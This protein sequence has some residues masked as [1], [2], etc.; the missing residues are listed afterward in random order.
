MQRLA[1]WIELDLTDAASNGPGWY[2][3]ANSDEGSADH[4][5]PP[6]EISPGQAYAIAE[7]IRGVLQR[8]HNPPAIP[9]TDLVQSGNALIQQ[10][11]KQQLETAQRQ[12]SRIG[13]LKEK[14]A[15]FTPP[16]RDEESPQLPSM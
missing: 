5:I 14:L 6:T 15:Q 12:I 11:L 8:T 4:F 16:Q 10:S 3:K 9:A 7:F 2:V 13:L 1:I